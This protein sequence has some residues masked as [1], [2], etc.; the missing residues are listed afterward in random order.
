LK[1]AGFVLFTL[2]AGRGP[3]GRESC[4]VDCARW[5]DDCMKMCTS[6]REKVPKC[7]ER[8]DKR[9]AKC[10]ARCGSRA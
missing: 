4:H 2:L 7:K 3:H 6:T 8:C 9:T 10:R 5:A 1:L